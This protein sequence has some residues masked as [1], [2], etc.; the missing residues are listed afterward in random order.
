[1]ISDYFT[2]DLILL[3]FS[4]S[5]GGYWSTSTDGDYSTGTLIPAAINLTQGSERFFA[6]GQTVRAEYKAY[7][8]VS[9]E[10]YQGRRCRWNSEDYLIADEPKNTLQKSHHYKLLLKKVDL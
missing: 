3:N 9:T 2:E 4:S 7:C 6:D 8:D 10:V 5:T 1:M